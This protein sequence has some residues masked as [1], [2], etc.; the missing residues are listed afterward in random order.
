M[1][2]GKR[3]L[4]LMRVYNLREGLT[5]ADDTLPERFFTEPVGIGR[6]AQTHLDRERFATSIRTYY[7][8]MG[9]DGLGRSSYETLVDGHLEWV[10]RDGHA[11]WIA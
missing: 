10:V 1:Q 6:W 9:W 11:D 5:A 4:D 2:F 3:R 8:M 7:R